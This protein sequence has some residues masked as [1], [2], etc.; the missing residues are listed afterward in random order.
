LKTDFLQVHSALKAMPDHTV[1]TP[2]SST[3]NR[4]SKAVACSGRAGTL[5][6]E[7]VACYIDESLSALLEKSGRNFICSKKIHFEK[8]TFT[9]WL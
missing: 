6:L 2:A 5:L 8:C 7:F 4:L 1:C 3:G 9:D